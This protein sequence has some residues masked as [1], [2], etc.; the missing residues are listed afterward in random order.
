MIR[1]I[2]GRNG[3]RAIP[4]GVNG[5]NVLECDFFMQIMFEL[6]N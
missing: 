4:E 6:Y 5:E 3:G 1:L 2:K